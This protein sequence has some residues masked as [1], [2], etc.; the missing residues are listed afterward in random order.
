M[1]KN[2]KHAE[3]GVR[4]TAILAVVFGI[5]CVVETLFGT[6]Y[7]PAAQPSDDVSSRILV[8]AAHL[9]PVAGYEC[10][11]SDEEN[12][13]A[14]HIDMD[15]V[16]SSVVCGDRVE[17]VDTYGYVTDVTSH[18][19]FV[20][21]HDISVVVPGIS[22]SQVTLHGTPVGFVSGWGDDGNLRCIAF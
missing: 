13:Y 18:E 17:F 14:V 5:L 10:I 22:G 9:G 12:D 7:A 2:M 4:I 16:A 8:T 3:I 15:Y 19:F 1:E 21:V 11:Y 20:D 6:P